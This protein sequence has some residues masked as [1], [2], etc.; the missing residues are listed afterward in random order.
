MVAGGGMGLGEIRHRLSSM[1]PGAP[2]GAHLIG[3]GGGGMMG[4][5]SLG[6]AGPVGALPPWGGGVP[7]IGL[8]DWEL[9]ERERESRERKRERRHDREDRGPKAAQRAER[10]G[11]GGGPRIPALCTFF[12]T[13]QGCRNGTACKFIH[14]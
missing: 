13:P 11:G 8:S 5:P 1:A 4:G 6:S 3:A 14:R 7:G 10:G 9:R 2:Q 12:N